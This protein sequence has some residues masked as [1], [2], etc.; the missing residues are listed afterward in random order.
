M[1]LVNSSAISAELVLNLDK[2]SPE[3]PDGIECLRIV[4]VDELDKSVL[5]SIHEDEPS[6]KGDTSE[7]EDIGS[8]AG[9]E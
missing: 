9:S 6:N 4:P 2:D 1:I 5:K 8:D 7:N 3:S